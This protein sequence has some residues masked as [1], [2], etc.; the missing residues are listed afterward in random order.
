VF[1]FSRDDVSAAPGV[2]AC[3]GDQRLIVGFGAATGKYDF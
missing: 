1:D 3:C 2:G